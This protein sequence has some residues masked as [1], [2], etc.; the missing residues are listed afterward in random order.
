MKKS[1][2]LLA[3]T[4]ISIGLSAQ[5]FT[6]ILGRPT[7]NSITINVLFSAQVDV[8]FEYGTVKGNYPNSTAVVTSA[9]N[10]P[11]VAVMT[12]LLPETRYYYRTRYRSTGTGTFLASSEHT[13]ITQRKPGSKFVF[14]IEAD[15]HPYDPKGYHPLWDICL[16]NQLNDGADFMLDLGDTFGDDHLVTSGN[17]YTT[18]QIQ[19]LML[20]NRPH[21]G[22]VCHSLPFFFCEGNHEGESGY[23]L[24]QTPPNNI[25]VY[26]T[27]W[28]KKYYSNPEP[29]GF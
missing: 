18:T 8:Y 23:Y 11:V 25:A 28:R 19:Q 13:F 7:N 9:L 6:E 26:E 2:T 15:P 27:I 21:F 12:G 24:L 20:D 5:T 14:T 3:L 29:D 16:Q 17:P 22:L 4:I 10:E 1:L